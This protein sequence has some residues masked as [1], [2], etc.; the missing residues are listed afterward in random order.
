M[1]DIRQEAAPPMTSMLFTSIDASA[2]SSSSVTRLRLHA[3]APR[4]IDFIKLAKQ[5]FLPGT[6]IRNGRSIS[7]A[8]GGSYQV[9]R[10]IYTEHA[11]CSAAIAMNKTFVNE[12]I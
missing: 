12:L 4:V 11:G 6:G 3:R 2:V 5:T 9:L 10:K 1:S 7:R 8:D